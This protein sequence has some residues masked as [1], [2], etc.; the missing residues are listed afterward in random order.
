[1]MPPLPTS[2][3]RMPLSSRK[4]RA[5]PLIDPDE[6]IA[7]ALNSIPYEWWKKMPLSE[8]SQPVREVLNALRLAG[9]KI[10]PR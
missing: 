4:P 8:Q 10:V 6:A 1:M 2:T 9:Y 3:D 5:G 7:M